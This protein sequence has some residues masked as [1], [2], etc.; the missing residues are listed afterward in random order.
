M[1]TQSS[2]F[3]VND[4]VRVTATHAADEMVFVNY[5]PCNTLSS[6]LTIFIRQAPLI[7]TTSKNM[8]DVHQRL[9]CTNKF[10]EISRISSFS[11]G[12]NH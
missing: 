8:N 1:H 12:V 4:C 5:S 3:H 7:I 9:L 2:R 6:H 11:T 10:L